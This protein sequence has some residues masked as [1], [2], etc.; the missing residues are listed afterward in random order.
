MLDPPPLLVAHAV[1]ANRHDHRV[2]SRSRDVDLLIALRAVRTD[3]AGATAIVVAACDRLGVT[4]PRVG[5]H[6]GR[7]PETGHTRPPARITTGL[8][9]DPRR[10]PPEGH[11]QL[12]ATPTLGVIAHELGHH[13]VFLLDPPGTPAHGHRWVDRQDEAAVVVTDLVG[14]GPD[15]RRPTP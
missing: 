1:V 15:Q 9:V 10:Y 5:T 3:R 14:L 13:L 12:S 8:D 4:A 6:A 2:R 7:R 11:V